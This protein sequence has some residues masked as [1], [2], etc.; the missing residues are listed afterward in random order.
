MKFSVFADL[1]H[2]PGV[3]MGG[4]VEELAFMQRRA[5]ENGCAFM[6]HAGDFTHG[7]S[8]FPD[9]VALYNDGR[10]T[11][12]G[13]SVEI[14]GNYPVGDEVTVKITRKTA[15]KVKFRV[16]AWSARDTDRGTWRT[17]DVPAGESVH[18]LSFDMSP[19]IWAPPRKTVPD[20]VKDWRRLRW[21]GNMPIAGFFRKEP[22]VE[23]MRG[24]LLLAKAEVAGTDAAE[25]VSKE[26]LLGTSPALR[27]VPRTAK[28][29][30]G[31]W[32]LEIGTGAAAK[33]VPVCDYPS[34]GDDFRD[35]G[36][37]FSVWF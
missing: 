6:I 7:P 18:R 2:Y 26:T 4:T 23:I 31:A 8:L 27:L 24:P 25:I 37:H 30:W 1:H 3:F 11:I 12:D 35:G 33:R 17:V 36:F 5:K 32:T 29:T 19:R 9:Y 13:D 34:A 22:G 14:S 28:D 21:G 16:P 10:A 20:G 15:G